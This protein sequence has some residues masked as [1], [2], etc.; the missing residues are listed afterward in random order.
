MKRKED[1]T[2][3]KKAN[4]SSLRWLHEGSRRP[5]G[6][7]FVGFTD[8]TVVDISIS[9]DYEKL[10]TNGLLFVVFVEIDNTA[11]IEKRFTCLAPRIRFVR[12]Y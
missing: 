5:R 10:A 4:C 12:E 1:E 9:I 11:A 6:A 2:L 7:E 8:T 3:A